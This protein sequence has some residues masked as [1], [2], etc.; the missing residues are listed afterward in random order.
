MNL[1][2]GPDLLE[3]IR[4][5][6]HKENVYRTRFLVSYRDMFIPVMVHHIAYFFSEHKL[7]YLV[8]EQGD[9]YAIDQTLEELEGS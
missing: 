5:M 2:A 8:T 1:S 4:K 7:V 9:R 3:V 6:Q